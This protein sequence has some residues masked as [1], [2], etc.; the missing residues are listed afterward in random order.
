MRFQRRHLPFIVGLAAGAAMLLA[1]ELLGFRLA[2]SGAASTFFLTYL[3][4]MGLRVPK[5]TAAYL[6][7][8]AAGADEPAS[9]ILLVT[10]LAVTAA[11]GSLFMLLNSRQSWTAVEL[12]LSLA[13]VGLGW[14]TIHAMAA[15]H[16]AHLYWRPGSTEEKGKPRGGLDFPGGTAPGIYDF[17]YFAFV[18]G[19][20][21]QTSDVAVTSTSMRKINLLHAIVS[22]LFNTVLV[23]AAVNVAVSLAT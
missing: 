7:A 17:L 19:M 3:A 4:L 22:F 9:V 8:N 14:F 20:T 6:Q 2:I 16:Y 23:A 15:V 21:A 11:V 1:L 13:T 18:V 12:V 5:L 10:A